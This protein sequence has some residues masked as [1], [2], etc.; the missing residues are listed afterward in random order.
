MKK[1]GIETHWNGTTIYYI[2]LCKSIENAYKKA[3][4]NYAWFAADPD[5]K[6]ITEM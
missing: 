5:I 6:A 3:I 1:Y 4:E 2:G